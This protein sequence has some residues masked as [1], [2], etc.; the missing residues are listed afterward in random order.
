MTCEDGTDYDTEDVTADCSA[1]EDNCYCGENG[2]VASVDNCNTAKLT[3]IIACDGTTENETVIINQ[4]VAANDDNGNTINTK[5]RIYGCDNGISSVE[6]YGNSACNQ[7][8]QSPSNTTI[9]PSSSPTRVTGQCVTTMIHPESSRCSLSPTAAPTISPQ[10]PIH[11]LNPLTCNGV[12]IF[13][14]GYPYAYPAEECYADQVNY[15]NAS[16]MFYCNGNE[17]WRRFWGANNLCSGTPTEDI[18]MTTWL[19]NRGYGTTLGSDW[20]FACDLDPCDV[21][22]IR[23]WQPGPGVVYGNDSLCQSYEIASYPQSIHIDER[24]IQ[25]NPQNSLHILDITI[26]I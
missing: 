26:C 8:Y 12:A 2:N 19:G 1:D 17:M 25:E 14:N 6:T 20:I 9:Q 5:Y 16:Y 24:L 22:H 15:F 3:D 23:T 21:V 10:V 11:S 4:C 13:V 18:S 7:T